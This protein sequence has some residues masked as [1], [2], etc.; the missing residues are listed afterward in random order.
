[1]KH[2]LLLFLFILLFKLSLLFLP[3]NEG[4]WSIANIF[5]TIGLIFL[6]YLFYQIKALENITFNKFYIV[7]F[8]LL[9][10]YLTFSGWNTYYS[11]ANT[12]HSLKAEL[13][14][15]TNKIK[16]KREMYDFLLNSLNKYNNKTTKSNLKNIVL[17][18]NE[19]IGKDT[20]FPKLSSSANNFVIFFSE[21]SDDIITLVGVDTATSGNLPGF[22]NF[23]NI[24]TGRIQY[25]ATLTLG[26]INYER[27]N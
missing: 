21:L 27:Q 15:S 20:K 13:S 14:S 9:I 2:I 3:L 16:L 17:N 24:S 23:A 12:L 11:N 5:A 1:M 7:I 6:F 4:L 22:R 19:I 25:K 26:G 18:S 10:T 8:L